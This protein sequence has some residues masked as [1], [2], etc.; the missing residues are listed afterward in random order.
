[1]KRFAP[2][3][4]LLILFAFGCGQGQQSAAPVV[5]LAPAENVNEQDTGP[6]PIPDFSQPSPLAM[7]SPD[8]NA[9]LKVGDK[10]DT[11]NAVFPR[12]PTKSSSLDNQL[13]AGATVDHW[14]AKGWSRDDAS[15][16]VGALLYDHRVAVAMQQLDS[17]T[18]NDVNAEVSRYQTRVGPPQDL[19]GK[20]VRYWFWQLGESILMVC[21]FKDAQNEI[22]LTTA[23]GDEAVMGRLHMTAS[24]AV[25]DIRT[26]ER[27]YG[28]GSDSVTQTH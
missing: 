7:I 27:L 15:R 8:S 10:E 21:A 16:G 4:V 1:M 13:P 17:V 25:D 9:V 24:T 3:A 12:S 28:G 23:L 26:V 18:E 20:H 6:F 2:A 19:E 5:P 22:N 11:F 14:S